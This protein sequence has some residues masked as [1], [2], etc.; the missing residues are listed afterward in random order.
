M[1]LDN[2][3]RNRLVGFYRGIVKKH[4]PHG[5]CK[6]YIPGVYS[7]EL[8][9]KPEFLPD[10]EP[11]TP[12][13]GGGKT[14]LGMFS[15]PCLEATVWCFFSNDDQNFP[16]YFAS[17]LG[18]QAAFYEYDE[19]TDHQAEESHIHKINIKNSEIKFYEDG[20]IENRVNDE[21]N[22]VI[23]EVVIDAKRNNELWL[24]IVGN[25]GACTLRMTGNGHIDLTSTNDI[26]VN[27]PTL[28]ADIDTGTINANQ[29]TANTVNI[30]V[31]NTKNIIVNSDAVNINCTSATVKSQDVTVNSSSTKIDSGT[32]DI[33]GGSVNINGSG[34]DVVVTG[35]SL[36]GHT[37]MAAHG[38]TS[39][40][41]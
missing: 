24:D 17:T 34:G 31:N 33:N 15:Y 12:L 38:P 22:N 36:I 39:P 20:K 1:I 2:Q 8:I 30:L 35:I 19:I 18:G 27:T 32:I 23:A 3:N 10:A 37:H 13:F 5:K 21:N 7:T 28:L 14:G 41:M 40:P 9:D 11:A 29:L 4:L 6:I 26:Y 25:N 16:V